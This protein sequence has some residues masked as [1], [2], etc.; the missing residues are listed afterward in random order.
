M[1]RGGKKTDQDGPE[2]RCI[3]T[4]QSQPARGLIRFV[5][6]PDNQ[7]VPD[8]SGRLPGRG[9]WVSADRAALDKAVAKKLFARA[10]RAPVTVPDGLVDLIERLLLQRVQNLLSLA[11]K[12]GQAVAGYEKCRD[13]ALRDEMEVLIQ[14]SDGSERGKTKLRPPDGDDTYIGLLT[15]AELGVAFGREVVIHAAL[16][17]GG[18]SEAVVEE[19]ARLAGLR[20]DIGGSATGEDKTDA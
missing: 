10:A 6:G 4:G 14:A 2:R 19:A 15:T 20:I 17:A 7:I 8:L 18:L 9:I 11:R 16:R 5:V 1:T 13:L 12:A 3:V